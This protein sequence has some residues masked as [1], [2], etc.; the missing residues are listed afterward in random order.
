MIALDD[1]VTG[2]EIR[3]PENHKGK[4]KFISKT[5]G[6]ADNP[7]KCLS[8][9]NNPSNPRNAFI[10]AGFKDGYAAYQYLKDIGEENDWQ[11][12]TNSNGEG[13]TAKALKHHIKYLE[14]FEKRVTCM[15]NDLAGK[16]A[17]KKI[18]Q[19]IPLVFHKLNLGKL[20]GI[21]DYINDFTDLHK[22]IQEH[23]ITDSVLENNI[24]LS[25]DSV[26]KLYLRHTNIKMDMPVTVEVKAEHKAIME[27]F[28]RGIYPYKGCYYYVKYD[29]DS[30]QLTYV[31]KSNF[32][33]NVTKTVVNNTYSFENHQEYQLEIV[34]KIGNK[35]T[36]PIILSQKELLDLKNLH[37]VLKEGG[38]HLHCLKEIEL[39]NI[40]LEELSN[41]PEE[42]IKN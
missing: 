29:S 39:K 28:E 15:D 40:L 37:D 38:I 7:E 18:E 24:K 14:K 1:T 13:N 23:G 19:E 10:C 35:I 25:P 41:I 42:L 20:N 2:F 9:I 27:F 5:K 32:S 36:K 31:K 4:F 33:L 34:T 30:G 8:K 17:T 3:T 22:Y 12:L 21:T 11:I 6:Y 16:K 26:L